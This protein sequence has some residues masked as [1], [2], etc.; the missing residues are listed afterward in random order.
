MKVSYDAEVDVLR[1]LF[2]DSPIEESDEEREGVIFDYDINGKL[3]G[4][5]ILDA[6]QQVDNPYA[7][8]VNYAVPH[9][10]KSRL[11]EIEVV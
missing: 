4:M 7:V 2:N 1:I 6:S 11:S 10:S 3:V 9:Y 5:E 8:E